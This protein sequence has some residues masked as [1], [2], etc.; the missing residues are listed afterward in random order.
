M[1]CVRSMAGEELNLECLDSA[2]ERKDWPEISVTIMDAWLFELNHRWSMQSLKSIVI[3]S[4]R[5]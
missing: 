1:C 3:L 2:W 4:T 5:S